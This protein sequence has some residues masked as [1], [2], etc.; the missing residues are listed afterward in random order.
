ML[1]K[2][3]YYATQLVWTTMTSHTGNLSLRSSNGCIQTTSMTWAFAFCR[4]G[5]IKMLNNLTTKNWWIK[6]PIWNTRC[7]KDGIPVVV[8]FLFAGFLLRWSCRVGL[9]FGFTRARMVDRWSW[10]HPRSFCK[11]FSTSICTSREGWKMILWAFWGHDSQNLYNCRVSQAAC[12]CCRAYRASL[13]LPCW[14][15]FRISHSCHT[16][17]QMAWMMWQ[18]QW[19]PWIW[20]F[21]G[22]SVTSR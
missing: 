13:S 1:R 12:F 9:F 15:S 14:A 18:G 20:I 19:T 4:S 10:S 17:L 5:K 6:V 16:S 11:S 21:R 7:W 8:V 2:V 3:L 22:V